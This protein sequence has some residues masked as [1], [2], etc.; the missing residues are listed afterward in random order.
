MSTKLKAAIPSE[1]MSPWLRE[2]KPYPVEQ[3]GSVIKLD[4]ME[5]PYPFPAHLKEAWL[6]FIAK[7]ELN[8][9][10]D[11][12]AT[13]LKSALRVNL[14]LPTE[15]ALIV[16]NGSDELIHML[17]LA[18]NRPG[19]MLLSPAPSFAVYPLAAKAVNMR[20]K[21]VPLTQDKFELQPQ[22]FID[23]IDENDPHLIFIAS[24][25]NP[26]GNKFATSDIRAIAEQTRGL[27]VLD[28]AYWRFAGEHCINTLFDLDNIVFMHTLSKI[29]LAG[30]RLG[31]LIGQ[32]KWLEPLERVRMP[33]NI[34]SLS[35]A[36]GCFA[37]E[38]DD[39][40]QQQVAEICSAR[41][42]MSA[43]LSRV[44]GVTVWPSET[45]FI[46]FRVT[47]DASYVHRKLLD[48]GV[49]IK[50]V[51]GAHAALENCLRVSIGTKEENSVFLDKLR[52]ILV[53]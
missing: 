7:L 35:Q 2:L 19:A 52:E 13:A 41:E 23:V 27:V 4:A 5:N 3:A 44:P 38:H 33:Y 12:Q 26:T 16:G 42:V 32:S 28:E 47:K 21:G 10:P 6:D 14:S 20:Y 11:P 31:V 40:F 51:H 24:P 18:Y 1:L 50:N 9:Y 17:C 43:E 37:I 30:V 15:A 25:N 22:R 29:G 39:A 45:N 48:A 46:L 36:T 53:A 49:M 34:S 8:R